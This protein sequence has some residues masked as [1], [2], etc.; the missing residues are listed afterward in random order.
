MVGQQIPGLC[1]ALRLNTRA[2]PGAGV[3]HQHEGGRREAVHQ[4]TDFLV[5]VQVQRTAHPL[6]T[7]T[8]KPAFG[9]PKQG[10]EQG[11]VI[12]CL[13]HAEITDPLT[14]L[15]L[16]QFVDLRGDPTHRVTIAPGDPGS[17]A[18]MLEKMVLG[19]KTLALENIQRSNPGR[20]RSV[21]SVWHREEMPQLTT[22][23]H[24][25]QGDGLIAVLLHVSL[26]FAYSG[27]AGTA[28]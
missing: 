21:D 8:E 18:R 23:R 10:I 25:F 5:D 22:L 4:Q 20:V 19:G 9:G 28:V 1:I 27:G 3:T 12:L 17:P 2:I 26:M 6:H 13:E 14:V 24:H 11:R 7:L 15:L 16:L